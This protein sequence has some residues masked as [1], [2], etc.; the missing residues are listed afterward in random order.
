MTTPIDLTEQLGDTF[1]SAGGPVTHWLRGDEGTDRCLPLDQAVFAPIEKWPAYAFDIREAC[2]IRWNWA[3]IRRFLEKTKRVGN[4]LMWLGAKSRG[5]GN[6]QWYGSFTTRGKTVRAHK[7][8]AV[9][10]LGLRPQPGE[11]L[12]HEC[13]ETLCLNVRVLTQKANQERIRR[14]TKAVL[15]LA[16]ACDLTPAEVMK[17][18]ADKI[19]AYS[20][21]LE[22][23]NLINSGRHVPGVIVCKR[24]G[25]ARKTRR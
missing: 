14:P 17:L 6:H 5:K 9:A 8:Y 1:P 15:D 3:D 24:T 23:A 7:F 19:A 20:R 12:D 10:V 11:E 2:G 22:V 16:K 25:K 13:H 21:L 18:P 4:H